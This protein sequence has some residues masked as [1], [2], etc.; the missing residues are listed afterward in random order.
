MSPIDQELLEILICP[1]CR[2]P[3]ELNEKE[4]FIACV[5]DCR[6]RYPIVD[7]IPHMLIDEAIKPEGPADAGS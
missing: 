4:Q 2:G 5:G 7:D 3:V 6:Y 1:N